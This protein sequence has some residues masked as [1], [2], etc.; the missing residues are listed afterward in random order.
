MFEYSLLHWTTFLT[1]TVLLTV[2]PG[3]D[4][5]FILGHTVRGGRRAG[6]AA[7][8]G[9]WTG[10]LIHLA[11]AAAGLSAILASSAIAFTIVKWVGAAYLIYLGV[12]AL[13]SNGGSFFAD[14]PKGQATGFQVAQTRHLSLTFEPEGR[15]LLPGIPTSI[16]GDWR[17]TGLGP[18]CFAWCANFRGRGGD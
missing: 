1:A 12:S 18:T 17:R 11:F 6:F 5:G 3:P 15:H 4:I 2:S 13:R 8:G 10:A 7:M 9:I 14:Q 16:C